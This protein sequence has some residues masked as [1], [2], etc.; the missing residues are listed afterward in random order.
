MNSYPSM[1]TNDVR[2]C[3]IIN[4]AELVRISRYIWTL[5][6]DR[7]LLLL[8]WLSEYFQTQEAELQGI[9]PLGTFS[10]CS[11]LKLLSFPSFCTSSRKIPFASLFYMI[12]YFI[13][14]MYIKPQGRQPKGQKFDVKRNLLSLRSFATSL[15]KIFEVWFIYIFFHDFIYVYSPGAGADTPRRQTFYVN[16]KALSLYPF[17]AFQRN[18]FEFWLYIKKS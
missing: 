8:F 11:I 17:V 7:F 14:N 15:K 1:F 6:F 5:L 13:P 9:Q 2:R 12:F 10:S 16:R 3:F 4:V 18:L